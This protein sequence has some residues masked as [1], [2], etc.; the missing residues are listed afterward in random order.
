MLVITGGWRGLWQLLICIQ[1]TSTPGNN[2]RIFCR[3]IRSNAG[4]VTT[5]WKEIQR[6]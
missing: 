6:V 2:G 5:A 3:T 1:N 4:G